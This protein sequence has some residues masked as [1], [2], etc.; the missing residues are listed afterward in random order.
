M[1]AAIPITM[2]AS[3]PSMMPAA[4]MVAIAPIIVIV[5][6]VMIVV[7]MVIMVVMMVIIPIVVVPLITKPNSIVES[8]AIPHNDLHIYIIITACITIDFN[9]SSHHSFYGTSNG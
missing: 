7:V 8:G 5:I 4:P 6:I 1:G 2:P 3:A 9:A